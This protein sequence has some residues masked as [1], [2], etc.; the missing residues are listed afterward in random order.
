MSAEETGTN[1]D[2]IERIIK[3]GLADGSITPTQANTARSSLQAYAQKAAAFQ[4][5]IVKEC[6]PAIQESQRELVRV[7]RGLEEIWES[8]SATGDQDYLNS[9]RDSVIDT[10]VDM[11]NLAVMYDHMRGFGDPMESAIEAGSINAGFTTP[12]RHTFEHNFRSDVIFGGW[13]AVRAGSIGDL[14]T[15]AIASTA[16]GLK[17]SMG[18]GPVTFFGDTR[19]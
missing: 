7:S 12:T 8:A 16:G 4:T 5:A 19:G 11:A 2:S 10:S 6:F 9:A 17:G 18:P 1:A 13:E 15:Q 14:E 3:E